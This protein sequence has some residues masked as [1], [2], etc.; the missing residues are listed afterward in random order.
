MAAMADFYGRLGVELSESGSV[1][2]EH[3]RNSEAIDLDSATFASR[4]WNTG[5]DP[6]TTGTVLS[7]QCGSRDEVDELHDSLVASGA[8]SAMAPWDA[9]WGARYAVVRDPD[10]NHVGL[11][12]PSDPAKRWAPPDP[13]FE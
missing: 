4:V 13:P 7:F 6:S 10:G 11:V 1:W 9:F 8:T 5:W 2:D 3:H 12:S